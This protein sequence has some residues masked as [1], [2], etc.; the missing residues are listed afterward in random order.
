MEHALDHVFSIYQTKAEGSADVARIGSNS[1][2]HHRC[3]ATGQPPSHARLSLRAEHLEAQRAVNRR[4]EAGER[5][6]ALAELFDPWTFQHLDDLG[7]EEGCRC[8]EVGAGGVSVLRSLAERVG[9]RGRVLATDIGHFVGE[10]AAGG[11][12]EVRRHGE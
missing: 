8:W 7:L 6:A 3:D 11:T 4:R 9:P 2:L 1:L 10:P 5:F 12:V